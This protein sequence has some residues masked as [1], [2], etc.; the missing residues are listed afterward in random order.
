MT[1]IAGLFS[2]TAIILAFVTSCNEPQQPAQEATATI[3]LQGN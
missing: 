1:Q 3:L 2:V